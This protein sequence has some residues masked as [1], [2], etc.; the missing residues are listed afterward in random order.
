VPLT[1]DEVLVECMLLVGTGRHTAAVRLLIEH[2]ERHPHDAVAL[3]TLGRIRLIEGWSEDDDLSYVEA[4]AK[5]VTH[6]RSHYTYGEEDE[7]FGVEH[8]ESYATKDSSRQS[9]STVE[10]VTETETDE[11]VAPEP[12]YHETQEVVPPTLLLSPPDQAQQLTLTSA[13]PE[14]I[15]PIDAQLKL[16]LVF[17]I[18]NVFDEI[19]DDPETLFGLV[20]D[21]ILRGSPTDDLSITAGRGAIDEDPYLVD[22]L[23]EYDEFPTRDDHKNVDT[24]GKLSRRE[25]AHQ[26]AM[27]LGFR[28]RWCERNDI[29]LLADVFETYWWSA[30]K[31][32]MERELDAGLLPE[33][34][35]LALEV[36]RVW[37]NYVEFGENFKGYSYPILG[38]PL[39]LEIVRSFNGYP[40][41]DPSVQTMLHRV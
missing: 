13:G 33:E 7:Q 37:E 24:E 29:E 35:R 34:L 30:A 25:R 10:S 28:Y 31:R 14:V 6:K 3:R 41:V 2:L 9:N 21:T 11:Q 17:E 22:D 5:E 15:H 1:R 36:R 40:K 12:E 26:I 8:Q 23:P 39:A 38:W 20:V 4:R 32:S 18:D 19:S 27:D 16:D